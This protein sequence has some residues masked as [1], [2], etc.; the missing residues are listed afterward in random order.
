LAS[1]VHGTQ[2]QPALGRLCHLCA[3]PQSTIEVMRATTTSGPG[4]WYCF[5][6]LFMN[7]V[8][9]ESPYW[10]AD[11]LKP[12]CVPCPRPTEHWEYILPQ[13]WESTS[14]TA[15]QADDTASQ[16]EQS[17][18]SGDAALEAHA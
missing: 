16:R 12:D 4:L 18:M 5:D 9:V 8:E 6:C 17:Q 1:E 11:W 10:H 3:L 2:Q 15:A 13:T 14:T 7:P